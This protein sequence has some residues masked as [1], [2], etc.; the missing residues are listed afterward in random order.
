MPCATLLR[1][2]SNEDCCI[3]IIHGWGSP[4]EQSHL[5]HLEIR[6]PGIVQNHFNP[7]PERWASES[8]ERF[9]VALSNPSPGANLGSP[10]SATIDDTAKAGVDYTT[11]DG[12]VNAGVDYQSRS[13]SLEFIA[14]EVCKILLIPLSNDG[15][16]GI[17]RSFA[18]SLSNAVGPIAPGPT[19]S[20]EI[21]ITDN[22]RGLAFSESSYVVFEAGK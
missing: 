13:G 18:L 12:T 3:R 15:L 22:D 14:D 10:T 8:L 16:L 4:K 11:T 17:N 1:P 21:L 19:Q 6:T 5:R 20:A 9:Q 2:I 7:D